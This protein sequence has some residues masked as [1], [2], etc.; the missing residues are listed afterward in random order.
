MRGV[1]DGEEGAEGGEAGVA[2]RQVVA[3]LSVQSASA[4]VQLHLRHSGRHRGA[5]WPRFC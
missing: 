4:G 2:G 1:V 3:V 5:L